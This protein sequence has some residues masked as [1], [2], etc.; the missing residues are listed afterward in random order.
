MAHAGH[1]EFNG[2]A[3][4]AVTRDRNVLV[5]DSGNHR[6]IKFS[7]DGQFC[8]AVGGIKGCNP[9][10]FS[11]PRGIAVNK[12]NNKVYVV[13]SDNNRVQILN[14]D[15]TFSGTFGNERGIVYVADRGNHRVQV[16]T[17]EGKFLRIFEGS[18]KLTGPSDIAIVSN[19]TIYATDDNNCVFVFTSGGHFLTSFGKKGEA[20]GEF[21]LPRG[22]AVDSCG[23]V[24]VCDYLNN[25]VQLF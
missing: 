23:V 3:G 6:I 17:A 15:L 1:G 24:Y 4:V 2:P 18:V 12:S 8:T 19:G 25:R 10:Q 9:L 16:F 5:V 11:E 21:N 14:S 13:D 20:K 7:A 22:V